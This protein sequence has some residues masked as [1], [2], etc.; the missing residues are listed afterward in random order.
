MED[1]VQ[2]LASPIQGQ[3]LFAKQFIPARSKISYFDGVDMSYQ[4]FKARYGN[5][6]HPWEFVYKR[7]PWQP[8]TVAKDCRNLITY[9]ND[10]VHG[11]LHPRVNCILKGGWL[12]SNRTISPGEELLLAYHRSYWTGLR[13]KKE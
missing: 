4:D 11:Q 6:P 2:I 9:V 12:I 10:G 13:R 1:Y 7:M 3:G 8:V 5:D